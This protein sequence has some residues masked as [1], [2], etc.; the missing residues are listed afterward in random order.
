MAPSISLRETGLAGFG[1]IPFSRDV[2][3]FGSNDQAIGVKEELEPIPRFQAQTVAHRFGDGGLSFA[4][5]FGFHGGRN[6]LLFT[7]YQK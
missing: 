6:T 5:E 4:A 7:Y 1:M 2:G 3:I